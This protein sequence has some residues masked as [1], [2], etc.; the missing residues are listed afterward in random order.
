VFEGMNNGLAEA[1]GKYVIFLNSDDYFCGTNELEKSLCLFD[2]EDA[3]VGYADTYLYRPGKK[4]CRRHHSDINKLPFADHFI[5]QS[6]V[7]RTDVIRQFGGFDLSQEGT[8]LENDLT[9]R[10]L[11]AN[12]KFIRSPYCFCAYSLDGMTGRGIGLRSRHPDIFLKHYGT[13]MGLSLEECIG[14]RYFKGISDWDESKCRVVLKKL[15]PHPEWATIWHRQIKLHFKN[16]RRILPP[17]WYRAKCR[18]EVL[19]LEGILESVTR[20]VRCSM[21]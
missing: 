15:E 16:G 1:R 4:Y 20:R 8:C 12:K 3:D 7:T 18:W 9:M 6:M 19:G 2:R 11:K 21:T 17:F 10:L 5:H 13:D 14:L